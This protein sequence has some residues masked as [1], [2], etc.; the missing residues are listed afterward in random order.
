M[1]IKLYVN[2]EDMDVYLSEHAEKRIKQRGITKLEIFHILQF[3][4]YI[5]KIHEGRKEAVGIV[6]KRRIKVIF[7]QKRKYIKIITVM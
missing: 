7:I 2:K 4:V 1:H 3:P 5:K 6:N